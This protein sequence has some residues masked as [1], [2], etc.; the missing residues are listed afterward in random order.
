M[1]LKEILEAS[2]I[3]VFGDSMPILSPDWTDSTEITFELNKLL[4]KNVV[5]TWKAPLSGI[6]HE[7]SDSSTFPFKKSLFLLDGTPVTASDNSLVLE[8]FPEAYLRLSRLYRALFEA[9]STET[10]L[11]RAY[12]L[13]LTVRPV[14]RYFLYSSGKLIN[15]G[16]ATTVGDGKIK[17]GEAIYTEGELRCFDTNGFQMDPLSIAAAFV[18]ILGKYEILKNGES[19]AEP[20]TDIIKLEQDGDKTIIYLVQPNGA[21]YTEGV[22]KIDKLIAINSDNGLYKLEA[23]SSI[24]VK[25]VGDRMFLIGPTTNGILSPQ[26]TIPSYPD[27][28]NMLLRDFF[29][30]T[31]ISDLESYLSGN[32]AY[33]DKP[34][35]PDWP[36]LR[37]K[38]SIRTNENLQLLLDGN[39]MLAAANHCID[40]AKISFAVSPEIH[41]NFEVPTSIGDDAH[42]PNFPESDVASEVTDLAISLKETLEV[43]VEVFGTQDLILTLKKLP[44]SAAVRIYNRLFTEDAIE[45]RGD[46]GGGIVDGDGE[47]SIYLKNPFGLLKDESIPEGSNLIFDLAVVLRN[48]KA[49]I[50]GNLSVLVDNRSTTTTKPQTGNNNFSAA[51]YKSVCTAAILGLGDQ[52]TD[53]TSFKD[54][55]TLLKSFE[56]ITPDNIR[57][58]PR[59]PTM[60]R[61]D[62]L[63]AGIFENEPEKVYKGMIGA[64]RLAPDLH[65][66]DA[67]IGAPGSLGGRETQA[68]G[69]YSEGGRITFD[70]TMAALRRCRSLTDRIALLKDESDWKLPPIVNNQGTEAPPYAAAILQTVA[71]NCETPDLGLL[72]DFKPT[73]ST[74]V[75]PPW[76]KSFP[77][78]FDGLSTWINY[79]KGEG[80]EYPHKEELNGYLVSLENVLKSGITADNK[81]AIF[82]EIK[83]EIFTSVFGARDAQWAI[84]QAIE[85]ARSFIY[86]EGPSFSDT[87]G[88]SAPEGRAKYALDLHKTIASRI[89]II[90]NL[91]VMV[92]TPRQLDYDPIKFGS[93]LQYEENRR[94]TLYTETTQPKNIVAFHPVGFPGRDSYLESTTIIVDDVWMMIGSSSFRRRGLTFDGGSDI[95]LTDFRRLNGVSPAISDF[96]RKL[97]ALR[98]GIRKANSNAQ[99]DFAN[100]SYVRLRHGA[101]AF[102]LIREQLVAGGQGY[103]SRMK[104]VDPPSPI[105]P[106]KDDI[107]I[108]NPD[109]NEMPANYPVDGDEVIKDLLKDLGI[110]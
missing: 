74:S 98:L 72:Q 109:G 4:I 22:G 52:K 40:G 93:F 103:I 99:G 27:S 20:L 65:N 41:G 70:I 51:T 28:A 108:M 33:P 107:D 75:T 25:D 79:I 87:N 54:H 36:D 44:P 1:P 86:I 68:S 104:K 18:K 62:L 12:D 76:A 102:S 59:Y 13:G 69:V 106:P 48:K 5:G 90:P 96:R 9:N 61:R 91:K 37:I 60:V 38:P 56:S 58:S 19:V 39:D 6:G 34:D 32:P 95:V 46:G 66:A 10:T 105:V 53:P 57:E 83:R 7:L 16:G 78:D 80:A 17:S 63:A 35:D 29:S 71:K 30:L 67:R 110:I 31:V 88:T 2:G 94:Y 11:S 26:F 23:G 82:Q 92:C 14:P 97:M 50:Y 84:Q 21:P 3:E 77:L 45:K 81:E 89:K 55:Y 49:R 15:A 64:G 8:L 73:T 47:M 24:S 101:D 100:P 85:N 43:S 42:F